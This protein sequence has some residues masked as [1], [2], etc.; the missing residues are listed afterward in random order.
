MGVSASPSIFQ[1]ALMDPETRLSAQEMLLRLYVCIQ[2]TGGCVR[3]VILFFNF[4]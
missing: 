2:L 1:L 3:L 4:C